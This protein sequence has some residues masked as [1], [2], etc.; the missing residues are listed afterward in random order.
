MV[1]PITEKENI[2][3]RNKVSKMATVEQLKE[4]LIEERVERI[5]NSIPDGHCPNA[6]YQFEYLSGC[7]SDDENDSCFQCKK[8]FKQAVEQKVRKE[9]EKL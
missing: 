4:M 3:A 7:M 8:R 6:Y 5:C 9:I 1:K 2:R